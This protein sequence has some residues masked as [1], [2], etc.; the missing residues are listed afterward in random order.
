MFGLGSREAVLHALLRDES[1]GYGRPAS[2]EDVA[3]TLEH[4]SGGTV[5][6]GDGTS[7]DL[8]LPAGSGVGA[9][10]LGALEERAVTIAF[11]L[12]WRRATDRSG[13]HGDQPVLRFVP[14]HP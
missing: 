3:S 2:S 6:H 11:A 13:V 9:G 1:R 12:G 4:V 14:V 7:V 8:T 10:R 5:R